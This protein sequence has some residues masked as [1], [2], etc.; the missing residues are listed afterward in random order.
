MPG[1]PGSVALRAGSVD[2][3]AARELPPA[4]GAFAGDDGAADERLLAVLAWYVAGATDLRGVQRALLGS[5]VLVPV[6]AGA[7]EP[8]E[9]H[10]AAAGRHAT[11]HVAHLAVVTLTG[12]DGRRGLPVFSSLAALAQW[13]PG[14]RPVPLL[15]Q[16]AARAAYDEGASALLVD[17]AAAPA[18]VIEGPALRALAEGRSWLAPPEDPEVV[19]A[20]RRALVDLPGLVSTE[21]CGATDADLL[22]TLHVAVPQGAGEA[23]V[24]ESERHVA[25]AAAARLAEVEVLRVRLDR[26]ID[27][28]VVPA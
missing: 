14:A 5:R 10:E 20:V 6:V 11:D 26:G 23:A 18:A 27:V 7:D 15:A 22:V 1:L 16:D 3:V 2:V 24:R 21:V 17:I 9:H 12:R 28:A 4:A 8:D 13:D 25:Q 19:V